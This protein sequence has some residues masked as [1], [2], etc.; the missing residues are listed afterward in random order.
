MQDRHGR[1]IQLGDTLVAGEFTPI[2]Y[3]VVRLGAFP[4]SDLV[5]ERQFR[6]G[7]RR[8]WCVSYLSSLFAGLCYSV[9]T[10][11]HCNG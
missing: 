2:R 5:I 10:Q 7:I 4:N 8:P 11:T 6:D 1:D 3:V 9:E